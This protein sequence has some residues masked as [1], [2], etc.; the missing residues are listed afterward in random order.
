M[1]LLTEIVMRDPDELV[2]LV[3]NPNSMTADDMVNLQA[4]ILE[5]GMLENLVLQLGTSVVVGGNHR[6]IA[7]KAMKENGKLP[8]KF[9]VP[10]GEF[11]FTDK[12]LKIAAVALNKV[13][14]AMRAA[15]LAEFID[16]VEFDDAQ[17]R[18]AGFDSQDELSAL[19][20]AEWGDD[21]VLQR[22]PSVLDLIADT[23]SMFDPGLAPEFD[24]QNVDAS[25]I[26]KEQERLQGAFA[27]G[28]KLK[29]AMCP[30]C[31]EEFFVDE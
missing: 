24:T 16:G 8:A 15:D 19:L 30:K 7:V 6:L 22:S 29:P 28:Q 20:D 21:D 3:G 14:G 4:S 23:P 27:K 26:A 12:Q 25:D 31:G 9:K 5:N 17:L 18:A 1:R 13:A 11:K 2:P 10:C